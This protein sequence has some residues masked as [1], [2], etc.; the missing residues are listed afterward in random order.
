MR[1]S[2]VIVALDIGTY[3]TVALVGDIDDLGDLTIIGFGRSKTRGID[4]GL[5]SKP[6]EVI[7]SIKEAIQ[8]A[9][10]SS[11]AKISSVIVN[12][13]G[14]H[15]EYRNEA[16]FLSFGTAQKEITDFDISD[17]TQKI[18]EKIHDEN[19]KL[20]HVIPKKF[21]LD[22]E[23][24]VLD[25]KGFIGS[26]LEGEFHI[27]LNKLNSHYNLKKVVEAA[28]VKVA[29]TV[30]NAIASATATLY[31]EEKDMGVLLIDIG[32]GTTDFTVLK[33]GSFEFT[34]S[35]PIGG[36]RVTLDIAHRFRIS[37][38]EAEKIKLEYGMALVDAVDGDS[39]IQVYPIG[40]EEPITISQY[41]L[42]ETMEARLDEILSLVKEEVEKAGY[43]NGINAGVVLTGGVANTPYIK[44]LA[45]DIFKTD[46]RIGRPKDYKGF[47]DKINSPEYATA[48]GIMLFK[49]NSFKQK[50]IPI[51]DTQ[52]TDVV[53][54]LKRI[55]DKIK[56]IF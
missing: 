38:D 6:N 27:I 21:I 5:I 23:D 13:G 11:G 1:A 31:P 15:I 51:F 4:R 7:R 28:G 55:L 49:K 37:K 8:Q 45:Q 17:L 53:G 20:I 52:D 40:G 41:E 16:D 39:D 29:D 18:T 2:N 54:F 32:A 47:S 56:T 26:K 9:S 33:D 3:K 30:A 35:V 12:V 19:Y 14:Y 44:E 48:V 43:F 24:E 22:D 36:D 25:P 46:V 42:V 50:D 10:A 34:K